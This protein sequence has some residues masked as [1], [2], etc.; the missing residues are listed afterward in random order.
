MKLIVNRYWIWLLTVALM[1]PAL[2]A[3]AAP[4]PDRM[5]DV[6]GRKLVSY[7]AQK[8]NVPERDIQ[9]RVRQWPNIQD[10][11]WASRN[12]TVENRTQSTD[13][14][15][16]T[17]WLVAHQGALVQGAY[18]VTVDI[19]VMVDAFVTTNITR[20]LVAAQKIPGIVQRT[21]I[22]RD[23]Q[24]VVRTPV[25][26]ENKVTR[27]V[28]P[29]GRILTRDM[30]MEPPDILKGDKVKVAVQTGDLV[31]STDG[32]STES[33]AIGEKV[34][35]FCTATRVYLLGTIQDQNTVIIE[36]Q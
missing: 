23:F 26:L 6:L 7:T 24:Q 2:S 1:L 20:R 13:V 3:A 34:R 21:R 27:Q 35:V 28:I 9:L 14:G 4:M 32:I 18:P 31:I 15:N 8:Y 29:A 17:L 36:V 33:G 11:K 12:W 10:E 30:L 16:Q 25:E 19:S 22:T 5:Q